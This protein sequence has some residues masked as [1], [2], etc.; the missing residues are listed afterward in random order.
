MTLKYAITFAG[1]PFVPDMARIVR[2]DFPRPEQEPAEG[3]VPSKHQPE[4]D[5]VDEVNRL[6]DMRLLQ[7]M[8][9]PRDRNRNDNALARIYPASDHP[10]ST[11][12][13]GEFYYPVGASRWSVFRGLAT[14]DMAKA[15]QEATTGTSSAL[16]SMQVVPISPNP[17]TEDSYKVETQMYMLPPRPLAQHGSALAGLYLITL[18]DVRYYWQYDPVTLNFGNTSTWADLISLLAS[19]LNVSIEYSALPAAYT[20]P[21][22]D[23]QLWSLQGDA[24]A[25]LDAIAGNLG[26]VV[27]RKLDG[28]IVLMTPQESLERVNASRG[29]ASRVT[30]IAGGEIFNSGLAWTLNG[31]NAIVPATVN[32][33]YPQY[34]AGN[35]PVPHFVNKRY[36]NQRPSTWFEDGFGGA[37][38]VSVPIQSGTCYSG[39]LTSGLSGTSQHT[40]WDTAKALYSGEAVLSG[41]PMNVSGLTAMAVQTARDVYDWQSL[42]ALDEVYPGTVAWGVEGFHDIVWTWSV[43]KRQGSTRVM[44]TEWNQAVPLMQHATPALSGYSNTPEGVGGPSV[45]QSWR[46]SFSSSGLLVTSLRIPLTSGDFRISLNSI[47]AMPTQNRFKVLVGGYERILLEGTSGRNYIDIVQRGIDGSVQQAWDEGTSVIPLFPDVTYGANLVTFEK[48]QFVYPQEATSGGIQGV[49]VVPQIQTV[50]TLEGSGRPINGVIHYSGRVQT[51]NT[52]PG[53]GTYLNEELVWVRDRN[54]GLIE[55][56]IRLGGQL[57]GYSPQI[58]TSGFTSPIYAVDAPVVGFWARLTEVADAGDCFWAYS[59]REVEF[60]GCDVTFKVNGRRGDWRVNPAYEANGNTTLLANDTC[61]AIVW[62]RWDAISNSYRF[63]EVEE[64]IPA[65]LLYRIAGWAY[66]WKEATASPLGTN[67]ERPGGRTGIAYE[68]NQ[69]ANVPNDTFVWIRL[70][71]LPD[72]CTEWEFQYESPPASSNVSITNYTNVNVTNLINGSFNTIYL[73]YN[74][75][76]NTY[77]SL[78][79]TCFGSVCGWFNLCDC[80]FTYVPWWC[81]STGCVQVGEQPANSYGPF[82]TK[83]LCEGECPE[84][85]WWCVERPSDCPSCLACP[86][87]PTTWLLEVP[88]VYN[89]QSAG[90]LGGSYILNSLGDCV[91]ASGV[92]GT[93]PRFVLIQGDDGFVIQ[94]WFTEL[95]TGQVIIGQLELGPDVEFDCCGTNL[96]F[97]NGNA[98]V[99][100]PGIAIVLSPNDDCTCESEGTEI[101]CVPSPTEP[102]GA[103][104]F[105]S[106]SEAECQANCAT[107]DPWWCV[108]TVTVATINCGVCCND[109]GPIADAPGSPASWSLTVPAPSDG[110]YSE[111]GGTF[112]L[113]HVDGCVWASAASAPKWTVSLNATGWFLIGLTGA[114]KSVVFGPLAIA[115]WLCCGSNTFEF[116]YGSAPYGDGTDNPWDQPGFTLSIDPVGECECTENQGLGV[117]IECVQSPTAPQGAI[118]GPKATQELCAAECSEEGDPYWCV[119]NSCIRSATE[120]QGS[121][122]FFYETLE[123]CQAACSGGDL[124][125]WCVDNECIPS[126]TEPEGAVGGSYNSQGECEEECQVTPPGP[127]CLTDAGSTGLIGTCFGGVGDLTCMNSNDELAFEG[128]G[129]VPGFYTREWGGI[130]PIGTTGCPGVMGS[131]FDVVV[132]ESDGSCGLVP[133]LGTDFD[134]DTWELIDCQTDPIEATFLITI[135][136]YTGSFKVLITEAP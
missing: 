33:V 55:N 53:M 88:A 111:L 128:G 104:G 83:A 107:D 7:D 71:R 42:A 51:I 115:S 61:G 25:L 94:V 135:V 40:I 79:W 97:D 73:V 19:A 59:Y 74:S 28:T 96:F 64:L 44:R 98:D 103:I 63:Y 20:Q 89:P 3:T 109:G 4:A 123:E 6:I 30:R 81:T 41:M 12:H 49:R 112:T 75:L 10:G 134:I 131:V 26:R 132:F 68:M 21:E 38:T 125:W 110:N 34:I 58:T 117:T 133:T 108:Q 14:A 50:T 119:N 121:T 52:I 37:Y 122:G 120:P 85:L 93:M 9:L 100:L 80:S 118:S 54:E 78:I 99:W 18:V 105:P 124:P 77:Q 127:C 23:S 27:V 113:T 72:D 36:N 82:Q 17:Y 116:S 91:W 87:P 46:D 84:M 22:K 60:N 11:S 56:G 31:R 95:R 2:M 76:T 102:E 32:V 130:V 8:A 62:L 48:S 90:E 57:I 29:V 45:A 106:A 16:F 1:V 47:T 101:V 129:S 67:G 5:L 92:D 35:D 136:G 13:I 65:K 15:M 126:A 66:Y 69:N 43:R 114:G 39:S 70:R 86:E 24:P